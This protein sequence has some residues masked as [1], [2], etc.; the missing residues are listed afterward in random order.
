MRFWY[1]AYLLRE[2]NYVFVAEDN[3][4]EIVGFADR[5]K[6]EKNNVENSGDLTSIY[7]L[8]EYQGCGI[9][10]KLMKQVFLKF[11][12]LNI[13]H[14]FV[15]VLKENETRYFYEYHGSKLHRSEKIINGGKELNLLTYEWDDIKSFF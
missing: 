3:T 5:G 4:G 9:G 2:G 14:V 6:R 12:E 7:L 15:E 13:N 11:V 8:K 1:S 10:K